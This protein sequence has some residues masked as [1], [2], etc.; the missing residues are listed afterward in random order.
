MTKLIDASRAEE[1]VKITDKP[2]WMVIRDMP[3]VDAVPVV[4]GRWVHDGQRIH[5]GVDWWH[6]SECNK[7]AAGVEIEY[8]YCPNCGADMRG[9]YND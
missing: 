4:H 9:T 8:N 1:L 3:A 6:C 5:N 2:A 7:T